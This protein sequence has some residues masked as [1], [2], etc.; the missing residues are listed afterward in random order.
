MQRHPTWL[1]V[2]VLLTGATACG[3]TGS[4]EASEADYL[5]D[6]AAICVD[7]RSNLD[8]LP[9]PPE[10]ISIA[11]FGT[12]AANALTTEA[13]RA[14]RLNPPDDLA[15]DHRAFIRN[16]D[17][18]AAAWRELS[19]LPGSADDRL[20]P[21]VTTIGELTLG[22]DDLSLEMGVPACQRNPG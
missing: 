11:D 5:T 18:Q 3:S 13:E 4:T 17:E 1:A 22:R 6:L 12:E 10:Q 21:I 16:T 14:R 7:T 15:D 20:D 19:S 2:V 9:S 8:S